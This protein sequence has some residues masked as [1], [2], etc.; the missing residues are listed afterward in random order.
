MRVITVVQDIL[1]TVDGAG[2]GVLVTCTSVVGVG[3]G[4]LVVGV[5]TGGVDEGK[6]CVPVGIDPVPDSVITVSVMNVEVDDCVPVVGGI[7]NEGNLKLVV[8]VEEKGENEITDS[9][10]GVD[11]DEE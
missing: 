8:V 6:S 9:V 5:G 10:A 2:V 1:V 11:T 7:E 3:L 4:T